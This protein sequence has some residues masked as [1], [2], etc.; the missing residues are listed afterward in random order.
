MFV[1]GLSLIFRAMV[2]TEIEVGGIKI[3]KKTI[4]DFDDLVA[5][6]KKHEPDAK[7]FLGRNDVLLK[8]ASILDP[9]T[10]RYVVTSAWVPEEAFLHGAAVGIPP[11]VWVTIE[12][13]ISTATLKAGLENASSPAVRPLI[14]NELR[15]RAGREAAKRAKK[16]LAPGGTPGALEHAQQEGPAEDAAP[17]EPGP[18]G[19]PG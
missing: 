6:I 13:G 15:A 7:A 12:M 5:A 14:Q 9:D 11:L 8:L 2:G 19:I 1:A 17:K 10:L 3:P 16:A 18:P 4:G